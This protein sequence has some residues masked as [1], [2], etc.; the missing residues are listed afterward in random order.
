MVLVLIGLR[1]L[2]FITPTSVL[3]FLS[4]G[5]S[6]LEPLDH[7]LQLRNFFTLRLLLERQ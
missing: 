7:C 5:P 2:F 3:S 1:L 6:S 4:N